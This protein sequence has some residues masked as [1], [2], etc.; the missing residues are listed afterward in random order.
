MNFVVYKSS[1][2]SGKTHT[3]V[4]EYIRLIIENPGRYQS[5]LAITFTNKAANEM[6]GRILE[7]LEKLTAIKTTKRDGK[8][9]DLTG[10]LKSH[11]HLSEEEISERAIIGL[12]LILHNYSGFAVST[13]D[14][15]VH[16]L[17]RS[18]ARDL[19][20]PPN[21]E[22]EMDTDKLISKSID[23]L[24]SKV[25]ADMEL[26]KALV[27]F[28]ETKMEDEKSWNIEWELKNL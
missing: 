3:L 9:N 8:F 19:R 12:S 2:G 23:L 20:L 14:S 18:F 7:D 5:I 10:S 27:Q 1:A 28:I 13:I 22:V 24:I 26:T 4:K 15:F 17:V 21:F 6:K 11:L 16:K 25:G